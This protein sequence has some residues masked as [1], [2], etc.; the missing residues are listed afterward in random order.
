[1]HPVPV[2]NIAPQAALSHGGT[3]TNLALSAATMKSA[4]IASSQPPPSA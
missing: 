1:M 2:P 4:I 3:A